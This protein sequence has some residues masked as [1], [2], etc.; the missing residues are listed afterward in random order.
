MRG[1]KCT[2]KWLDAEFPGVLFET[3]GVHQRNRSESPD[4]G[5]MQSSTVV[6]VEPQRRIV[7][8]R[9]CES[10]VVDQQRASEARL[11]HDTIICVEVDYDQL[12]SAPTTKD[13]GAPQP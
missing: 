1:R 5:V 7:E 10:A 9:P 12:C 11:H 6:E 13:G 8:L 4:V 3:I 2:V